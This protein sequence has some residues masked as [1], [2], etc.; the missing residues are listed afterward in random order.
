[1]STPPNSATHASCS[2]SGFALL[3]VLWLMVAVASLGATFSLA[4]REAIA[5]ARNR[6]AA[7]RASWQAYDCLER[8]RA[9]IHDA[10]AETGTGARSASAWLSLDTVI[11]RAGIERRQPCRLDVHVAGAALDVNAL[12]GEILRRLFRA[13]GVP[14]TRADSLTDALLDWRDTDSI[15][16]LFGAE[17]EWYAGALRAAPR[18]APLAADRELMLVRGFDRESALHSLL[19]IE[20]ARVFFDRAP[21]AVIAAL[22]GLGE[23]AIAR[24][25]ERR[26][27]GVSTIDLQAL[28]AELS[29]EAQA[30]MR[31]AWSELSR[32]TTTT[33]DAWIIRSLG[34]DEES[35]VT[36]VLEVRLVRAGSRA[37]V[38]R[39]REWIE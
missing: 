23:E 2:R 8:A 22:P 12:D 4:A 7:S 32:L 25:A 15:P 10:L 3:A 31:A 36:A 30:S 39:R 35:P 26:A 14:P 29:A 11:A 27:R 21:L 37:A 20:K 18:N 34:R 1:M 38:V 6:A 16:R 28:T 33:P 19:S 9:A 24:V 17:A 5:T 13:S